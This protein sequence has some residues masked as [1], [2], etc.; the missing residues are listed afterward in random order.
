MY[1]YG[2]W[3]G[4]GAGAGAGKR[5]DEELGNSLGTVYADLNGSPMLPAGW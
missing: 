5:V 1:R 4:C 3:G 2:W